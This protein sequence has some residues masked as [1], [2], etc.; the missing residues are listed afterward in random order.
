MNVQLARQQWAA[1]WS[2]VT[3]GALRPDLPTVRYAIGR[4]AAESGEQLDRG[5]TALRTYLEHDAE[6]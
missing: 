4:A 2:A 1:A 5:E 3:A 6:A